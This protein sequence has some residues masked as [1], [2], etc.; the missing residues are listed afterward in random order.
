MNYSFVARI[1]PTLYDVG[2]LV[3]GKPHL[4]YTVGRYMLT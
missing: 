1:L 2:V 4:I 3:F